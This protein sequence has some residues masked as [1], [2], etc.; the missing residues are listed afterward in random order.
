[1]FGLFQRRWWRDKC[2]DG[3]NVINTFFTLHQPPLGFSDTPLFITLP[4]PRWWCGG[5][6]VYNGWPGPT[7]ARA[8][9]PISTLSSLPPNPATQPQDLTPS[10]PHLPWASSSQASWLYPG[11]IMGGCLSKSKPGEH[12]LHQ[13]TVLLPSVL[14][15]ILL[16]FVLPPFSFPPS[17]PLFSFPPSYFLFSFHLSYPFPNP[18][19]IGICSPAIQYIG[20]TNPSPDCLCSMAICGGGILMLSIALPSRGLHSQ[21]WVLNVWHNVWLFQSKNITDAMQSACWMLW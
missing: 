6:E 14:P 19:I 16:P 17:Y 9:T 20:H 8:D 13:T 4:L 5:A 10:P 3:L 21:I 11:P 1:M 15:P 18:G 12:H 7:P 2:E